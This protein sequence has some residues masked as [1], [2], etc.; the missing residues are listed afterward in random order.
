MSGQRRLRERHPELWS[1][2]GPQGRGAAVQIQD[3]RRRGPE[4]LRH[5]PLLPVPTVPLQHL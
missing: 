4:Q 2:P 3:G 1:V 5:F